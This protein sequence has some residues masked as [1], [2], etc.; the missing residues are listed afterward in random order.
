MAP[1]IMR[2][3][4]V[5]CT[6]A[7]LITLCLFAED[8]KP[9]L[10]KWDMTSETNGDPVNWTLVLKETDGKLSA[11][12]SAGQGEAP[13]K[14]FTYEGGVLKFKA[15]YQGQDYDIELKSNGSKLEG[16]W[17][18]GGDSGKVYGTKAK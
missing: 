2:R 4:F 10:G 6:A 5:L 1:N 14:S 7:F 3:L 17:S 13:A 8:Y 11:I 18:G 16:T 15:P 12:L 9:L